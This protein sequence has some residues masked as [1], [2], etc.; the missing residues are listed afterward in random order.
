MACSSVIC[1]KWIT[2]FYQSNHCAVKILVP[3]RTLRKKRHSGVQMAW[4]TADV[5][6][7]QHVVCHM[8]GRDSSV[9]QLDR[10]EIA[11]IC[12]FVSSARTVNSWIPVEDFGTPQPITLRLELNTVQVCF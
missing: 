1:D 12:R 6:H 5:Y 2:A 11:L 10:A 9:I 4:N 8:V 3:T 7:V